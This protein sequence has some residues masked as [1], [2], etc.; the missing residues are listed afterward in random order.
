MATIVLVATVIGLWSGPAAAARPVDAA[1]ITRTAAVHSATGGPHGTHVAASRDSET[2]IAG[3]HYRAGFLHRALLGADYRALWTMPVTVPVLNLHTFAGGLRPVKRVGGQETLGLAMVGADGRAW[4]FRGIDKDPSNILPPEFKGTIVSAIVQDQI[5]SSLPGGSVAVPPLLKAVDV[6]HSEPQL[7]VMPDDTLLG[8]FRRRFAGVF[9]TIELY[10]LP[11]AG[12]R[13]GFADAT[14]I[15]TGEELWKRTTANSDDRADA[16]AFL[17]ARLVDLLVGD[18]DRHRGQWRWARIPGRSPWQP[19][20]EDRDQAFCRFEGLIL[21]DTRP[22]FPWFVRF[23]D[24]YPS[25]EGLTWNGRDGDRRILVSLDRRTWEDVAAGVQQRITDR[26][27]DDAVSRLPA[28]YR[29]N[30]GERLAVALRARRDHLRNIARRF[31]A[32]LARRVDIH[33]TNEAEIVQ[34]NRYDDGR[35]DVSIARRD[36]TQTRTTHAVS[37]R[38]KPPRPDSLHAAPVRAQWRGAYYHRVFL[39]EE[40]GE[41]RLYL[42]GGDDRVT[43]RGKPG[44]IVLRVIG[45][46]GND[47]VD[48]TGAGATRVYDAHGKNHVFRGRRTRVDTRAYI[49]PPRTRAPWIPPRDWGSRTLWIPRM[50]ANGDLGVLFHLTV[51]RRVFG[52]RKDPYAGRQQLRATW[53]TQVSAARITY[54]GEFRRENSRVRTGIFAHVSSIEV[55]HFYGLGNETSSARGHDYFRVDRNEWLLEPSL[56]VPAG[57]YGTVSMGPVVQY[58]HTEHPSGRFITALRPYGSGDFLQYGMRAAWQLDTRG[59]ASPSV[60]HSAVHTGRRGAAALMAGMVYPSFGDV[61]ETYGEVHGSVSVTAAPGGTSGGGAPRVSVAMRLGAKHVWGRFPYHA[62]AFLGGDRSLRGYR[63]ERFAGRTAVFAN[64]EVRTQLS[65]FTL[66]VPGTLGALALSDVGRVFASGQSS[67]RWH[68]D[69]GGGLWFTVID[70]K[71]TLSVLVAHSA[72]G[73]RFYVQAGFSY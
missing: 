7:V 1:G 45:G 37:D 26:V 61:E 46:G 51:D 13:P 43:V 62:A 44:S 31:Y 21:A 39:P 60:V 41:V 54:A 28:E 66:I 14:E 42:E 23:R 50:G 65:R 11:T 56:Q 71:N 52:F 30:E 4:T 20:P 2:V 67:R 10:P 25:I 49:P 47:T 57:P 70:P 73:T 17:T 16:R 38:V 18:W 59:E 15:I 58:S 35:M 40:T 6:L 8:P 19:I 29:K 32:F 36:T 53:A 34:V 9:G 63:R 27:I 33:A 64:A 22:R 55:L 68:A 12:D 69:A 72:E 3:V 5:A 48:D 24:G